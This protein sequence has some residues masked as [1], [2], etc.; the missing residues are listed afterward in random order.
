MTKAKELRKQSVVELDELLKNKRKELFEITNRFHMEKKA[1]QP[2]LARA[3]RKDIAR[4]LT[5][6]REVELEK[7]TAAV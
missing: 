6:L 1:D 7:A 3:I 5:L 2:H 4:I